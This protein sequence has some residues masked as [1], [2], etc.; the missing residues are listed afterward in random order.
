MSKI[1]KPKTP[2]PPK[3]PY[4]APVA[5]DKEVEL[6]NQRILARKFAR[7]GRAGTLFT[8]ESSLG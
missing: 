4:K 8:E 1:F 7:R 5:D 2:A 3:E 6:A